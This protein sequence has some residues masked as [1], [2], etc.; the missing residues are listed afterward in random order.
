MLGYCELVQVVGEEGLEIWLGHVEVAER[1]DGCGHV[2]VFVDKGWKPVRL[3]QRGRR[4]VPRAST[5]QTIRLLVDHEGMV[6]T[7]SIWHIPLGH[8]GIWLHV[9]S[10]QSS[11]SEESLEQVR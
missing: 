10:W 11:I 9:D 5:G 1:C 2:L 3:N 4:G 6:E 8:R 7:S